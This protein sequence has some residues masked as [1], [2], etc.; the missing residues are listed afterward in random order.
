[1]APGVVTSTFLAVRE[2]SQ[3][4][5]A[6]DIEAADGFHPLLGME[7]SGAEPLE[8]VFTPGTSEPAPAPAVTPAQAVV[9]LEQL[10]QQFGRKDLGLLDTSAAAYAP[11]GRYSDPVRTA[12]QAIDTAST[13]RE[14]SLAKEIEGRPDACGAGGSYRESPL[15]PT[16]PADC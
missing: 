11:A 16:R 1:M 5:R 2:Q 8:G 14:G 3:R 12:Q 7:R 10:V 9:L 4:S 15:P 6:G 13:S